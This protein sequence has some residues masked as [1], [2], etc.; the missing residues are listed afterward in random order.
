MTIISDFIQRNPHHADL[1]PEDIASRLY[2]SN[3]EIAQAGVSEEDF[4]KQAGVDEENL[5]KNP[6]RSVLG[7]AG[8]AAL[9]G[10]HAAMTGFAKYGRVAGELAGAPE[11]VLPSEEWIDK[12]D[13]WARTNSTMAP[14]RKASDRD[15]FVGGALAPGVESFVQSMG[16]GV[17]GLVAGGLMGGLPGA[18]I[19]AGTSGGLVFGAAQYYDFM[20]EAHALLDP[21]LTEKYASQGYTP[22]AA[23]AHAY[24][25][26]DDSFKKYARISAAAEGGFE[27]ISNVIDTLLLGAGRG[28]TTPVKG[29]IKNRLLSVAKK[30]GGNYAKVAPVEVATE[31]P[32][33]AVQ[34]YATN[35]VLEQAGHAPLDPGEE[36]LRAI[37]PTMVASA[38]FAGVGTGVQAMQAR[39]Q[40][41]RQKTKQKI[42]LLKA[43]EVGEYNEALE[44]A[45]ASAGAVDPQMVGLAK[46]ITGMPPVGV[47]PQGPS[48]MMGAMGT[49]AP[50]PGAPV[51]PE[52]V[53]GTNMDGT[54]DAVL[55][56]GQAS[57]E[58]GEKPWPVTKSAEESA[59]VLSDDVKSAQKSAQVF[60]ADEMRRAKQTPP[61]TDVEGLLSRP[62]PKIEA[63]PDP[64]D[65]GVLIFGPPAEDAAELEAAGE[66]GRMV[67]ERQ[68]AGLLPGDVGQLA[69]TGQQITGAVSA[70]QGR[71]KAA[72]EAAGLATPE[73]VQ[74]AKRA[75]EGMGKVDLEAHKAAT[76]P[77]NALPEPTEGQKEAGNYQKGHVK[78]NGLNISIENPQESVRSGKDRSGKP[79]ETTMKEHYG[80]IR[81]TKGKDKDHIDVFIGSKAEEPDATVFVVDQTNPQTGDFDEHKVLLGYENQAA[82]ENAYLSNYE[83]G[84]GGIGKMTEVPL[85]MFK[86]WAFQGGRRTD[87]ADPGAFEKKDGKWTL[88]RAPVPAAMAPPKAEAPAPPSSVVQIAKDA[89][90]GVGRSGQR[91]LPIAGLLPAP[92]AKE[93]EA[94]VVSG[95]GPSDKSIAF[96][97][98]NAHDFSRFASA[99]EGGKGIPVGAERIEYRWYEAAMYNLLDALRKGKSIDEAGA[100]AKEEARKIIKKHNAQRPKDVTWQRWDGAA[101][102]KIDATLAVL[103]SIEAEATAATGG[104]IDLSPPA[105][106]ADDEQPGAMTGP[107]PPKVTPPAPKPPKEGKKKEPPATTAGTAEDV[108]ENIYRQ[109][110]FIGYTKDYAPIYSEDEMEGVRFFQAEKLEHFKGVDGNVG[111]ASDA[112]SFP[113]EDVP[114]T[115][116]TKQGDLTNGNLMVKPDGIGEKVVNRIVKRT[117]L[118]DQT[119]DAS[120]I[121]KELDGELSDLTLVGA[122]EDEKESPPMV[123]YRASNGEFVAFNGNFVAWLNKNV[124]NFSLKFPKRNL[125]LSEDKFQGQPFAVMS[126]D[127]IAGAV[128]PMRNEAIQKANGLPLRRN[129]GKAAPE[130]ATEPE[131][132]LSPPAPPTAKEPEAEKPKR[133]FKPGR[134]WVKDQ[135][136]TITAARELKKGKHKGKVEVTLV[137]GK[138]V[139]VTAD[140]ITIWP[141]KL[142]GAPPAETPAPAPEAEV[143]R[144]DLPVSEATLDDV[145]AAIEEAAAEAEAEVFR[146]ARE[147]AD[148]TKKRGEAVARSGEIEEAKERM[149][150]AGGEIKSISRRFMALMMKA[151]K[152]MGEGGEIDL[153]PGAAESDSRYEQLKPIFSEAWAEAKAANKSIREFAQ[154]ALEVLGLKTKD[155]FLRWARET[156]REGQPPEQPPK[157]PKGPKREPQEGEGEAGEG[158]EIDLTE[159]K[160]KG[161]KKPKAEANPA[162]VTLEDGN[163]YPAH[164]GKDGVLKSITAGERNVKV[165]EKGGRYF[166]KFDDEDQ[167]MV[168]SKRPKIREKLEDWGEARW[169]RSSTKQK[170]RSDEIKIELD[171]AV[172]EGGSPEKFVKKLLKMTDKKKSLIFSPVEGTTP[173]AIRYVKDVFDQIYTFQRGVTQAA[174]GMEEMMASAVRYNPE[175]AQEYKKKAAEYI[176]A[177]ERI[178]LALKGATD[179]TT[180]FNALKDF[181]GNSENRDTVKGSGFFKEDIKFIYLEFS[182]Y[183]K[184]RRIISDWDYVSRNYIGSEMNQDQNQPL[185]R[186][187][188][189][190]FDI[191][192]NPEHR[193]GRDVSSRELGET[194]N[195]G[196]VMYGEW[197]ESPTRQTNTNLTYDS[198]MDLA[199]VLGIPMKGIGL[200]MAKEKEVTANTSISDYVNKALK[201]LLGIAFGVRGHGGRFAA[202]YH[203]DDHTINLTKTKGDGSLAHEWG[204]GF[205]IGLEQLFLESMQNNENE[206]YRGI[207]P[208]NDLKLALN[209]EFR[210]EALFKEVDLI[211]RGMSMMVRKTADPLEDAKRFLKT[212]LTES[213]AV[214]TDFQAG[215]KRLDGGK[216]PPYWNDPQ[217]KWAR[218]FESYVADKL[219]GDNDYLVNKTYASPGYTQITFN[220]P[221]DAAAYPGL[222][223][224]TRFAKLFD[225]FFE[226]IVWAE[227]GTPSMKPDYVP[228]TIQEQR[229][230]KKAA[231]EIEAKLEAMYNAIHQGQE[232]ADGLWWYAYT[233]TKRGPM[234]QPDGYAAFDDSFKNEEKK[235]FAG[236]IGYADKLAA[237]DVVRNKLV[238]VTHDDNTSKVYLDGRGKNDLTPGRDD[239]RDV[240]GL[241]PEDGGRDGEGGD[242]DGDS[243]DGSGEGPGRDSGVDRPRDPGVHGPREGGGETQTADGG[244][245]PG[246][247]TPSVPVDYVIK[248]T[249]DLVNNTKVEAFNKNLAALRLLK[250]IESEGRYATS[251][252]QKIL[253]QYAGWGGAQEAFDESNSVSAAWVSR[254]EMLEGLLTREEFNSARSTVTTSF[255]TPPSAISFMYD[256][257]VKIGFTGGRIIEPSLGIGHFIG[258][259]PGEMKAASSVVGIEMDTLSARIAK[260]LYPNQS[261]LTSPFEK[262]QFPDGYNDL[263]VT[264]VPFSQEKP[265]DQKHNPFGMKLHDYFISK[266]L[267]LVREGGI[268]AVITSSETMDSDN[269]SASKLREVLAGKAEL[270]AA[271][272]L[273]GDTFKGAGTSI[274]TDIIFI[275]KNSE[276]SHGQAVKF[277]EL[278]TVKMKSKRHGY[279]KGQAINEY[280]VDNPDMVVGTM[281]AP[282]WGSL[283]SVELPEAQ[284]LEGALSKILV[285]KVPANVYVAE[286]ENI[287]PISVLDTIPEGDFVKEGAYYIGEDGAL[288][289]NKSGEAVPAEDK[290]TP[291]AK[292]NYEKVKRFIRMR[293]TIRNLLRA[294]VLGNSKLSEKLRKDLNGQYDSFVATYGFISLPKN[295]RPFVDDPDSGM[296]LALE[297]FDEEKNVSTRKADIF[298]KDILE[299]RKEPTTSDS[300]QDALMQSFVWRGRIDMDFISK[301]TGLTHDNL[302]NILKGLTYNDPSKGWVLAEEY[303]S[304]NVREKLKVAMAA[305]EFD[306]SYKANVEAL[307]KVQPKSIPAQDIRATM[308]AA[309]VKPE[310]VHEFVMDLLDSGSSNLNRREILIDYIPE[311]GAWNTAVLG[312][313]GRDR[314][315]GNYTHN[316]KAAERNRDRL[317]R[318]HINTSEYGTLR[319]P[320]IVKPRRG[321][322]ILECALN[323]REPRV[324]DQVRN[325]KGELE[326]VLN[327]QETNAA[328]AKVRKLKQQ[329]ERWVWATP[330]RTAELEK[331]YNEKM[332]NHVDRVHNGEHLVF[333]GKVP[334]AVLKL[335]KEQ[336]NAVWRF[337][338]EGIAYL[339][340]EVGTGKTISLI[341]SIME[342]RRLGLYKKP[343]IVVRKDQRHQFRAEFLRM[344]PGANVFYA[345]VPSAKEGANEADQ[346]LAAQKRKVALNKIGMN[347]W[348]CVII[349]HE[350]FGFIPIGD[351]FQSRIVQEEVDILEAAITR[352]RAEGARGL[353]VKKVEKKLTKL[354]AKLR[355]L[356]QSQRRYDTPTFEEMGIDLLAVDEAHLFKNVNYQT[357]IGTVKG[358]NPDGSQRGWDMYLK[359]RYLHHR[360]GR[361]I[362][363]ASGTPVTNSIGELFTI[364]RF[365]MPKVL[366]ETGLQHFDSW[367][368]TF[369]LIDSKAMP[370]PTGD[371]YKIVRKFGQFIN[372]PELMAM[373]RSRLDIKAFEDFADKDTIRPEIKGGKPEA[374][375]VD[376]NPI[377]KEAMMDLKIRALRYEN[378]PFD[379]WYPNSRGELTRDNIPRIML[380]GRKLAM[381]PRL[382]DET[383]PDHPDTKVNHA[384]RRIAEIYGQAA[385][386]RDLESGQEY[387]EKRGVQLVFCDLGVPKKLAKKERRTGQ[388]DDM[389]NEVVD[390]GDIVIDSDF[391]VYH[392]IKNKLVSQGVP[393]KEIDFVHNYKK[394]ADKNRLFNLVNSGKIRILIGSTP[395]M[396]IGINVQ[397]RVQ[398]MHHLDVHWNF[399]NY[400]QRNGRGIRFGNRI[401]EVAI[402]NYGMKGTVD[403]FMWATVADKGRVFDSVLRRDVTVREVNDVSEDTATA[404]ELVAALSDNPVLKEHLELKRDVEQLDDERTDFEKNQRRANFDLASIPG[405]IASKKKQIETLEKSKAPLADI[406]AVRFGKDKEA[407]DLKTKGGEAN[408]VLE[409]WVKENF[410]SI[411]REVL[412]YHKKNHGANAA[413]WMCA[414]IERQFELGTYG[415]IETEEKTVTVKDKNGKDVEK[416][417]KIKRFIASPH[418]INFFVK[419]IRPDTEA[420]QYVHFVIRGEGVRYG[421]E[422][423]SAARLVSSAEGAMTDQIEKLQDEIVG[424][425]KAI[426]SAKAILAKEFEQLDE[427]ERKR[428][429]LHETE[430]ELLRIR[431]QERAEVEAAMQRRGSTM[432]RAQRRAAE[433]RGGLEIEG[434]TQL[435]VEDEPERKTFNPNRALNAMNINDFKK[436]SR[437]AETVEQA[438][439]DAGLPQEVRDRL[440]VEFKNV[441]DLRGK[442]ADRSVDEWA[443]TGK[444]M[445][446]ILGA[447]TFKGLEAIVELSLEQD[448]RS[449]QKTAYHEAF[450]M[451][452]RWILTDRQFDVLI[453][454]FG[455]EERAAEAYAAYVERSLQPEQ[456]GFVTKIFDRIKNVLEKIANALRGRGYT[457]AREI[458]ASLKNGELAAHANVEMSE[459]VT[460][461]QAERKAQAWYSKMERVLE[462]KLPARMSPEQA[463]QLVQSWAKGGDF[464]LEE[465]EWAMLPEWIDAQTGEITKEQVLSYLKENNVKLVDLTKGGDFPIAADHDTLKIE[466]GPERE[467][468][469]SV[470]GSFYS[471]AQGRD[472]NFELRAFNSAEKYDIDLHE[473]GILKGHDEVIEEIS[474]GFF[475]DEK[476]V[477]SLEFESMGEQYFEDPHFT[478]E[479]TVDEIAS[480]IRENASSIGINNILRTFNLRAQRYAWNEERAPAHRGYSYG[481]KG[482]QFSG[483]NYVELLLQVPTRDYQ[484]LRAERDKMAMELSDDIR[485]SVELGEWDKIPKNKVFL[486][487][488]YHR[489]V[490]DAGGPFRASQHW[491]EPNVVVHVRG[492]RIK[493]PDG[494]NA[495]L[496][497]EIQSDLHQTGDVTGY[498]RFGE[499]NKN[500]ALKVY[501][502]PHKKSSAWTA[503]AIRRAVRYAVE[504]GFVD[505][506][507]G[508]KSHYDAIAFTTGTEQTRFWGTNVYTWDKVPQLAGTTV[509]IHHESP[510]GKRTLIRDGYPDSRSELY[511]LIKS[512][513]HSWDDEY[514][515]QAKKA[516]QKAEKIWAMMQESPRGEYKPR[517]S[518]MRAYYD[519][520]VPNAWKDTFGKKT[521]GKPELVDTDIFESGLEYGFRVA[522]ITAE[523]RQTAIEEGFS[524][525]RMGD[526]RGSDLPENWEIKTL[527]GMGTR[528]RYTRPPHW[529]A[530]KYP[531]FKKVYERNRE[532]V[533]EFS[534]RFHGSIEEVA[535]FFKTSNETMSQVSGIAFAMEHKDV[536]GLGKRFVGEGADLKTSDDYYNKFRDYLNKNFKQHTSEARTAYL[537]IRRS[538]DNDLIQ[539]WRALNELRESGSIDESTINEYRTSM[540]QIKNYFP[541]MRYGR[542][543]IQAIDAKG[544]VVYREHFNA[545]FGYQAAAKRKLAEIEAKMPGL[546][547]QTGKVEKLPEEV[548]SLPIPIEALEAVMQ[549]SIE[550]LPDA[551]SKQALQKLLPQAVSDTLKTRGWGSH[552]IKRKNIAGFETEDMKRVLWDYKAGLYG[553]LT[554]MSAARDFAKIMAAQKAHRDPVLWGAMREYVGD[555]L[556]NSD[557]IDRA[558]NTVKSVAFMKYLGLNIK[559]AALN[560]TQN[561]ISGI[562]R[563]GLETGGSSWKWINAAMSDLVALASDKKNLTDNEIQLLKE[564]YENG[565]TQANF[566]EEIKGQIGSNNFALGNKV[567]KIMGAPMGIAERFN[568]SSLA[569]AAFRAAVNGEVKNEKTLARY[570]QTAGTPWDYETAKLF[571]EEIVDDAHF[572]YGKHN[573]PEMLRGPIGR[574]VATAYTFRTFTHNLINLWSLFLRSGGRG[575]AAFAKSFIASATIGGIAAIPLYSTIMHIVR[576]AIGDDPEEWLLD[577]I[578]KDNDLLRDV[579]LYGVPA[580]AGFTLGGSFK[581]EVPIA[582]RITLDKSITG[583]IAAGF[584]EIV[585]IPWAMIEDIEGTIESLGS[586]NKWRALEY[587][588]PT[589]VANIQKAVRLSTEGHR[590]ASGQPINLPG[591]KGP[592][593][594]TRGETV[595]KALGFQPVSSS[596]AWEIQQNLND[597]IAYRRRI[598]GGYAEALALAILKKD[599]AKVAEIRKKIQEWN[600][601]QLESGR[602][603]YVLKQKDLNQ[604][605][606]ARLINRKLPVPLRKKGLEM[607]ETLY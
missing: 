6:D 87:P 220:W 403:S 129:V 579:I 81:G 300:P 294:Q 104:E 20:R 100:Y 440:K 459:T 24:L 142:E 482:L 542:Y 179:T 268:V 2:K 491:E 514:G 525:F 208:I 301:L 123:V 534:R 74:I 582:E 73:N 207:S 237:E 409:K 269:S 428:E 521:F 490:Q 125:A 76:S 505:K 427:L 185:R 479:L 436:I 600:K 131:I 84:W 151:N 584:G 283:V 248:A 285:E 488:K 483:G 450:H 538:L 477:G 273:P 361:G 563:L 178:S 299:E 310:V 204:H 425:E 508:A 354:K 203:P 7:E 267:N 568:R 34:A 9:R 476:P 170:D 106:P 149:K 526:T 297:H 473:M 333:P 580:I 135:Q 485:V 399:A 14:G 101:D 368:R 201:N 492:E 544:D 603:E 566:I 156:F 261:I 153:T 392:D 68:K 555:M 275:R 352:L 520:I 572:V 383:L 424:D 522:P 364:M 446:A 97:Q 79:W 596:K 192:T 173:G 253:V 228:V 222:H 337:L 381:D 224:R 540:G 437:L 587:F 191:K 499:E 590:A 598:Q 83:K 443:K 565:T 588:T 284:T 345:D 385:P 532:R 229:D 378:E 180:A 36:A 52:L 105:P 176:A 463:K 560:L 504:H 41:Q 59:I 278:K 327:S 349:T 367:V 567:L 397:E 496:I 114:D 128:M 545:P 246:G 260:L 274:T 537:Q 45:R 387:M 164:W 138:K 118:R 141:E 259:M 139:K 37:P 406:S 595:G 417:E 431:E 91:A 13:E 89:V 466:P 198:L 287:R 486:A 552:L 236:A 377:V 418:T 172:M 295:I 408:A 321:H 95:K 258:M 67:K 371:G 340:H 322:S 489:A 404:E 304:G 464:K 58:G 62:R 570:K 120:G 423:A 357:M 126:G 171:S 255:W 17:P 471:P 96:L 517:L 188:I 218:A 200:P 64:N 546:K 103:R 272:R 336:K 382:Y 242:F 374:V 161:P 380:D 413:D 338:Q 457:S 332:N 42:D 586:S 193:K 379:T 298:T 420:D 447:T 444:P 535:P 221:Q 4:F 158:G 48:A 226:G 515:S 453:D 472:I 38:G 390:E 51:D 398:A 550:M 16:T 365:L 430:Q 369:G 12:Q 494:R 519:R 252:E 412:D 152:I 280:F 419:G 195:L 133:D 448:T 405:K 305:A 531:A 78:I 539:I 551:E 132:D 451:A 154:A 335:R 602:P 575:R 223:D 72:K 422:S 458:F 110:K 279:E 82:A 21:Q 306:D 134:A 578:G 388:R 150:K 147:T 341:A 394:S 43:G 174:R 421:S 80:Y 35:P 465:A 241:P 373:V 416:K 26:V 441:I 343:I 44:R 122:F 111:K 524:Q 247:G 334:D 564:L 316:G 359:T 169:K 257:L 232:S 162:T 317:M 393:E 189:S 264:N 219:Q 290:Q 277:K 66:R 576:Q 77:L 10:G 507:S 3:P 605:V 183:G 597:F 360:F 516:W 215:A 375:S 547:L 55:A 63:R 523:M 548:Y 187:S 511:E 315:S 262:A 467:G 230:F 498:E 235:A 119:P 501:D 462:K 22:E 143:D 569:L 370:A 39:A 460:A 527:R 46:Q 92:E 65:E 25:E 480:V 554:K 455:V 313:S 518:G 144:L 19:G 347:D 137:N 112:A 194:F 528:E 581:M 186:Q 487:K 5:K 18:A 362:L 543:Y 49:A 98:K 439:K 254:R 56:M 60:V 29:A 265:V 561:F 326:W 303:L 182:T 155:L 11:A 57:P 319:A 599:Q 329:F 250:K 541:H 307:E 500:H 583:Q 318:D 415:R 88:K 324:E 411:K 607:K 30:Y 344:Y 190:I 225:A 113:K 346:I 296:M 512:A 331:A 71:E 314:W 529:L 140:S 604:A 312:R 286:K 503:L 606:R 175:R 342:G 556:Q 167:V 291:Q 85:S 94:Q 115:R 350:S 366:Q 231:A 8:S 325:D 356:S 320:F 592:R 130:A 31:M 339:G 562:P 117:G 75:V 432:D 206:D 474:Y 351:D 212:K 28:L 363:F 593:K 509:Q 184:F 245:E 493:L 348:D 238:P 282:D 429:R 438:F 372:I 93:A 407:L 243:G 530:K 61:A 502:A 288:Y 510:D 69:A 553:W 442:N 217:E 358:I 244:R 148:P 573:R 395:T 136:V 445:S 33:A 233:V 209:K 414:Q 53:A 99:V 454:A 181:F 107:K 506:Y 157:K 202:T 276:K 54:E 410:K 355:D 559:T 469:P 558:L 577:A 127:K 396:G 197:E 571:A 468:L 400:E 328:A 271:V 601:N 205:D 116:K 108:L 256:A 160:P 234:L 1:S 376:M 86:L 401:K 213:F 289:K 353:T 589:A 145:V 270:L 50:Q 15:S 211:L 102:A 40:E 216:F 402:Y 594:L 497:M 292:I 386:A 389:G 533:L 214:D 433:R 470:R 168:T 163:N 495:F 484:D 330:S 461:L 323:N 90:E 124:P 210:I 23:A 311:I 159:K 199:K 426:E 263:A 456:G 165:I 240:A 302:Y 591:E 435:R 309:W 549:K 166:A 239:D 391:S 109:K 47:N 478:T 27:G 146:K 536:P 434:E 481:K 249:D 196:A 70:M 293:T 32:T 574:F 449:M 452:S 308:G 513:E 557:G 227:D 281:L 585:G 251:E 475:M 121:W 266:A 384:V 177:M